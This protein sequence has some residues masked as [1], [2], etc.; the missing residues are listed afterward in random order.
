MKKALFGFAAIVALVGTIVALAGTPALAADLTYKAPCCGAPPPPAYSWTGCY[1]GAAGGGGSGRTQQTDTF[2]TTSGPYNQSGG[3]FGGTIGCNYQGTHVASGPN[4]VFG[5]EA[6]FSW[7]NINGTT[8]SLPTLCTAG[9]GTVCFTNMQWLNTDRGR[10]GL[11]F[12]SWM[13]YVTVGAASASIKTGQLSCSTPVA[14]AIASCGTNT[15]W[16][17]TA[18]AG[19]EWMFLPNWSAKV[20]YLRAD[21]GSKFDAYTVFIPVNVTER[22]DIVRAGIDYHF[23]W[24][25][26]PAPCCVTK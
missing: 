3:L 16:G 26:A 6:D 14:G 23:N 5:V 17:W 13:P 4:F 22:V 24:A 7:A 8:P 1:L 2:G 19:V 25:P 10:L 15:E 18:G 21:F 20:E 11:A 12:G 9:S